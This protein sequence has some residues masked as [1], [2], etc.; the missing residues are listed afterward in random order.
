MSDMV[1]GMIR[2]G[3]GPLI[4][5]CILILVCAL[6]ACVSQPYPM[7]E[8]AGQA[9]SPRERQEILTKLKQRDAE[10]RSMRILARTTID[11][12][13]S[14]NI[15]RYALVVSRPDWMRL[16]MLP[17]T[18]AYTLNLL[19]STPQG[20]LLLVPDEEQVYRSAHIESLLQRALG[21]A[22]DVDTLSAYFAGR[23]PGRLLEYF[24]QQGPLDIW[25]DRGSNTWSLFS[26]DRSYIFL[27][28]GESLLLKAL[29]LREAP[30]GKLEAQIEYQP[31]AVFDNVALPK[32]VKLTL[33]HQDLRMNFVLSAARVN[34]PISEHLFHIEVPE[35][36]AA[37][38]L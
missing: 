24:E 30:G 33:P 28:D 36:Y 9:A 27:L 23:I 5:S 18:G 1:N 16:E 8:P 2:W 22:L 20:A 12:G 11:Q 13:A 29:Q 31:A 35:H 38:D 21:L 10:L 25:Y 3:E 15:V 17:P 14:I 6:N 19:V 7:L 26:P 32:S 34:Q 37:R 4:T